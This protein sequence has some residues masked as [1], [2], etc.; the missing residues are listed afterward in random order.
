MKKR[1]PFKNTAARAKDD[2][3]VGM[4]DIKIGKKALWINW[5]YL[6][7]PKNTYLKI[8]DPDGSVYIIDVDLNTLSKTFTFIRPDQMVLRAYSNGQRTMESPSRGVSER[9]MVGDPDYVAKAFEKRKIL[10][11]KIPKGYLKGLK[12]C[13]E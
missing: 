3:W 9:K 13:R 4:A 6:N 2:K 5:H 10:S 12:E 8:T 11:P 1:S 7:R